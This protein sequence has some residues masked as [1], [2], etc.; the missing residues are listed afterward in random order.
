MNNTPQMIVDIITFLARWAGLFALISGLVNGYVSYSY[1]ITHRTS[2]KQVLF[3]SF[4]YA[5]WLIILKFIVNA[6]FARE[7]LGGGLYG[8]NEGPVYYSLLTGYLETGKIQPIS[9]FTTVIYMD[10]LT[11]IGSCV[12]FSTLLL[13][14]LY[15]EGNQKNPVRIMVT[16]AVLGTIIIL[17]S[18]S[19]LVAF[20]PFYVG[21]IIDNNIP[22]AIFLGFL[23]GDTQAI[24]PFLGYAYYGVVLGVAATQSDIIRKIAIGATTLVGCLYCIA[25]IIA[26]QILGS[27]NPAEI[28]Q[29]PSFQA[30]LLQIGLMLLLVAL[31]YFVQFFGKT[32]IASKILKERVFRR[33]GLA[34]L[35]IYTLE[36][37]L[38]TL[39]KV[40]I[41]DPLFP[42]WSL[43]FINIV[44]YS[45]GLIIFWMVLLFFW[46]KR[47]F[48]GS[49]EWMTG[50]I[51]QMM[52]KR[53]LTRTQSLDSLS[54]PDPVIIPK[55][56]YP[57]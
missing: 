6:I 3:G 5:L 35:T 29:P 49:F 8:L 37:F 33:F 1:L 54:I 43:N 57:I 23:I 55:K 39:V 17:I 10:A 15:Q 14:F 11:M 31:L 30:T 42:A 56:I 44:I 53:H 2:K 40:M 9:L 52:T 18:S 25:G 32:K 28:L 4:W 7:S 21:A 50:K 51:L 24:F 26:Y 22:M 13:V 12:F 41:L 38:G 47:K 45:F 48:V 34:S 27:P 20:R 16:F 36:P 19:L 46:E